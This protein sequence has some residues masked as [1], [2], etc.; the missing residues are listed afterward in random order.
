MTTDVPVTN[1]L[2]QLITKA[3]RLLE[4]FEKWVL[5]TA[6]LVM[7]TVSIANV[8]SRNLWG[9]SFSF[10]EEVSQILMVL[11]TFVGIG[12]GVRHARHIRMSAVYDQLKGRARKTLMMIVSLGTGILLMV[13]AWYAVQYVVGVYRA[14]SV[15]PAMRIPLYLIYAWVPIG[16]VIGGIQYL[17][18]TWRNI[19]T[20]GVHLSFQQ[21]EAYEPPAGGET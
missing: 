1:R 7:A 8:I 16:F 6:I 18:A 10:A 4:T 14:G 11:I 2:S 17:L 5:S 21:K 9:H 19:T 15:T 3:D 13:L 12:Y 20:P